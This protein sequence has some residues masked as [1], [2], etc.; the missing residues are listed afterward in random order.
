MAE[1]GDASF[2]A[3]VAWMRRE[4]IRWDDAELELTPRGTVSGAGVRARRG[5]ASG[6]VVCH[7]P[8][9]AALTVRTSSIAELLREHGVRP[10]REAHATAAAPLTPPLTRLQM[11]AEGGIGLAVA[12]MYER[13]LGAASRRAAT[14]HDSAPR[15]LRAC[16]G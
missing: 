2:A 8:K 9:A 13:S 12:L 15:S 5:V 16:G 7:I 6:A 1:D 3:F 10:R 14:R 11:G 4:G